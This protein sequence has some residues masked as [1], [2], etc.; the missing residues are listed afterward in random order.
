M[1]I[2]DAMQRQLEAYSRHLGAERGLSPR[3][4]EAYLYHARAFLEFMSRRGVTDPRAVDRSLLR[5]Q[6]ASLHHAEYQ[7]AGVALRLSAVRSFFRFL[8]RQGKVPQNGLWTKRSRDAKALTPKL[9][10]KLPTFLTQTEADRMVSSPDTSTAYGLRDSAILE[11]VYAA[12]LRV[13]EA[14]SL[15]VDALQLDDGEVRV[16]GKGAKERMGLLG[17]PAQQAISRYLTDARPE[18]LGNSKSPALFLNRYGRR[19]SARSIQNLVKRY[20]VMAGLDPE[21]VHTHTLRHS[22]ATHL[23]DGG[24]DLRVVQELLGHS[25]PS[26]TQIYTHVTQ[27]QARKVYESAHP[28]ARREME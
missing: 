7:K 5:Q 16:W 21:R 18:L 11:L 8:V 2:T 20:A 27:T 25:S 19:L 6:V 24:A 23:L 22:F 26:T 28:L 13:S 4:I 14:T 15:D 17:I 9:D 12:G 3:T 1:A 10:K